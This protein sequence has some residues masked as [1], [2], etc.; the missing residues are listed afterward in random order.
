M[1]TASQQI[2]VALQLIVLFAKLS[3][4]G[5]DTLISVVNCDR[6]LILNT[7]FL[8]PYFS[9]NFPHVRYEARLA[10]CVKHAQLLIYLY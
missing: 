8:R 9:Y 2:L 7:H 10:T 6:R 5:E 1:K 4:T 3:M